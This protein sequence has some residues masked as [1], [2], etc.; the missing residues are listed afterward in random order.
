[1]AYHSKDRPH[2]N[3]CAYVRNMHPDCCPEAIQFDERERIAN[4]VERFKVGIL[5][6]ED[7]PKYIAAHIRAHQSAER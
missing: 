4:E 1:M 6:R 5:T 3:R 2:G 7:L